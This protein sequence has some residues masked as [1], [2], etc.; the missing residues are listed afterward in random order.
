MVRRLLIGESVADHPG[1]VVG[2]AEE[3]D[4]GRQ[5][6]LRETRGHDDRR[7]EL[8]KGVDVRRALLVDPE[9]LPM[10]YNF[11]C[12]LAAHL[13]DTDAA[14]DML[15]TALEKMAPGLLNHARVD[16]D[17]DTLRDHPRFKAMI[18]AAEARLAAQE[19]K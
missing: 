8:K 14:L 12:A 3:G 19:K 18:E 16:P 6:V 9:N 4:A 2:P 17:L 15:E 1:I 11:A 5:I 7:H 10:R 13:K